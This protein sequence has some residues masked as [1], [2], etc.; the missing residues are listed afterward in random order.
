[1]A[2]II[3]GGRGFNFVQ[4]KGIAPLQGEIIAKKEKKYTEKF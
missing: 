1:L 2:Q 3:L 4:T